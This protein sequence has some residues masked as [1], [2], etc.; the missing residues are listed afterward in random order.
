MCTQPDL[1]VLPGGAPGAKTFEE[2]DA[3]AKLINR[4][5][6]EGYTL[7]LSVLLQSISR[8]KPAIYTTLD[9]L[10]NSSQSARG[11]RR[12]RRLES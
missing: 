7:V 11:I 6:K 3:V 1:I 8:S 9:K 10:V 2:S 4:A 12:R 5:Q